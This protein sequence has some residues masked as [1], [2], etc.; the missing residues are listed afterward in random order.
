MNTRFIA[1]MSR[2]GD[3]IFCITGNFLQGTL[4][5]VRNYLT[6]T[7]PRQCGLKSAVIVS[8]KSPLRLNRYYLI[9]KFSNSLFY[10]SLSLSP[11]DKG[12][13]R[14]LH[15]L[16]YYIVKNFQW[17]KPCRAMGLINNPSTSQ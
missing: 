1:R 5:P 9:I 11:L 17:I 12:E 14:G 16:T 6:L 3:S 13:H 4:V 8:L 2:S 7:W 10:I 15:W